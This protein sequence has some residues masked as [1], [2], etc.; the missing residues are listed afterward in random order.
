MN[1]R[2]NIL[3][4]CSDQQRFDTLGCYGNPYVQTP[5]LDRLAEN[6][7]V[8]ENAFCQSPVCTPSRSSFLT[9][10]YP[11]TCRTRQNGQEIPAD[12][13]LVT[14]LLRD[15]GGY[16]CGL[17]GKL[18]LSVCST[19]YCHDEE[20]RIDDGYTVFDWSHNSRRTAEG[21]PRG[22]QYRN[23]LDEK[24]VQYK[25]TP[26]Q[27]PDHE[28]G[29]KRPHDGPEY[30]RSA[31]LV[32]LGMPE[33]YHHTTWCTDRAIDF[34]RGA[35]R[36]TSPW[37]FSINYYDPHHPM[38]PPESY[39]SRYLSIMDQI[40]LPVFR[41]EERRQ[42][43]LFH[44][45]PIE[46]QYPFKT[47][48]PYEHRLV[49]AAYWAAIDLI[50][51][52]VGRLVAALRETDQLDDTIIIFMSDHGEIL[53]DH[54]IYLK[55]PYFY[56]PAI[57]VPLIMSWPGIINSGQRSTA[58]VELLDIAE[59]LLDAAG[60]S[61]FEGMQGKSLWPMLTGTQTSDHHKEDVYCEYYNAL[62]CHDDP[63][64]YATMLRTSRYKLVRYHGIG[65][66]EL[67]DLDTDP[68]EL[69]NLW[70][71]TDHT[72]AKLTMLEALCDRMAFTMDPL[73]PRIASA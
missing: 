66:G 38:D 3:W 43:P 21:Y 12:E 70:N 41:E 56:E 25:T 65:Q 5:N 72:E 22:N 27:V 64:A 73:P 57:K 42:Q 47:M 48:T 24:N 15:Q 51:V 32:E 44:H 34:I 10:R 46:C 17:G 45:D 33:E 63:K 1:R 68:G 39:L 8:F 67:Y 37:L 55:G 26:F 11:R 36:S 54:G 52:Q 7:T 6:G 61:P 60:V 59:T 69:N 23:W 58:L 35:E 16:R 13:V 18:H 53:G 29:A 28:R 20:R 40:P 4:I 62:V 14:R 50:D 31:P 71:A 2:P 30:W 9:G 49:K 19:D